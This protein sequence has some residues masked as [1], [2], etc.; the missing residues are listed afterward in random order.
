MQRIK[1]VGEGFLLGGLVLLLFLSIF[2]KFLHIP[3]WLMVTGHMHPLFLHFPIVLL[4]IA[5]ITLWFPASQQNE[6]L[7]VVIRLTAALSAVVT[8]IMGLILS[9]ETANGGSILQWHKW[10]GI[11]IAILGYLFYTFYQSLTNTKIPGRI[12]TIASFIVILLTGDF[13]GELTHGKNY[14]LAPIQN[15]QHKQVP[16]DQALVFDDI[17]KPIFTAK[18]G[19]CHGEGNHKGGLSLEDTAAVIKGGKSGPLFV[20][21]EPEISLILK[22]IHLPESDKR[23]MPPINKTQVSPEEMALLAAWIRSGAMLANKLV[24]L[25]AKDS[26]RVLAAAMLAPSPINSNPVYEFAAADEKTI[27]KLNNNYRVL[28]PQGLASP[29]L[30]VSFYG[31]NNY[32][33]KLLEELL[34][35]KKQVVSISLSRMP[36]KDEDL[37]V[38]NQFPNLEKLNLNS[39]DI[40]SKGLEQLKSLK[41]IKELSLSGTAVTKEAVEKMSALPKLNSLFIWNTKIDTLQVADLRKKFPKLYIENGFVDNPNFLSQLSAPMIE[42]KTGVFDTARFIK[43]K[44]PVK[45][46]QLRYSLDGTP[47]DSA[48]SPVYKDSFAIAADTKLMVRAFKNGWVSS[49]PVSAA[50]IKRGFKPDS[51]ELATPP[52]PKY[53]GEGKL[54]SDAD[55]GDLNF[56]SGKWLGYM[57][58]PGVIYLYFNNKVTLHSVLVNVM[59]RTEQYVFLPV[60]LEVWGGMNKSQLNLLGQI[61]PTL[62][63]KNEPGT[64]VQQL[65]S[66]SPTAMK[67]IK[68]VAKPIQALP[69]WHGGKGK[70]GWVFMSEVVLN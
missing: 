50:F 7:F 68:I 25:P 65:V 59:K 47:P 45:G 21:G 1:K 49:G 58:N 5:F 42:S 11:S 10:G 31:R 43:M 40:T 69:Q 44:H 39:T 38:V 35:V 41:N 52:D 28:E 48:K 17:I 30:A 66:F 2:E 46:V 23:H 4:C 19:S 67:C 61:T 3:N 13:G 24:Q 18:C 16:L 6:E 26:F 34:D 9:Q 70:K 56:G 54:L 32:N 55:L 63:V 64:L 36:V 29:A 20:S 57:N 62:P 33:K 15:N 22:R 60:K 51:I 8:A 27:Q 14:L 12:F 37:S 53:K